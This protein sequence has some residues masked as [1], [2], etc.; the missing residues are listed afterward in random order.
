MLESY[1]EQI[2]ATLTEAEVE[3]L[4]VGGIA[5]VLQGATVVTQDID[6]C[7]RRTRENVD[8]LAS[9]LLGR[10]LSLRIGEDRLPIELDG[11]F[12]W[13]GCNFTLFDDDESLD[14]LGETSGIGGYDQVIDRAVLMEI[15][16]RVIHVLAIADPIET[17]RAAGR[18]KDLAV[19]PILEEL[20][21]LQE[22][23]S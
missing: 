13:N 16:G 20:K 4:V 3:Y 21:R 18:P 15:S 11:P 8:K 17:K 1:A 22:E 10:N 7:Y 23:G 14:L 9:A 12:L 2:L 5:A 6:I 19:L